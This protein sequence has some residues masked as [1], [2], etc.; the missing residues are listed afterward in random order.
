MLELPF[1]NATT[2]VCQP[3]Q[4][5]HCRAGDRRTP[6]GHRRTA[7][8]PSLL[9]IYQRSTARGGG[10]PLLRQVS[11]IHHPGRAALGHPE[12][13]VEDPQSVVLQTAARGGVPLRAGGG[14]GHGFLS[15]GQP[16]A[17][18]VRRHCLP[19]PAPVPEMEG[20]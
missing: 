15:G 9:G 20:L 19:A 12:L 13:Y 17:G 1:C 2:P 18:A 3:G 16:D 5:P 4:E 10:P 11:V 7:D 8:R 6:H 14:V